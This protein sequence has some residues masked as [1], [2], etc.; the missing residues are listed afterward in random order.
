VT[1]PADLAAILERAAVLPP[2]PGDRFT[3]YAILGVP[4]RSG[5][6]LALRRF[7]VASTGPGYTSVWHRDPQGAWT[8]YSDAG[9]DQDGRDHGCGRYFGRAVREFIGTP[10]RIEWTGPRNMTIA[11]QG[12]RLLSWRL[13][14][15]PTASTT[16]LNAI[17]AHVPRRWLTDE[18]A[19]RALGLAAGFALGA[20]R[21]SLAGETPA[22]HRFMASPEVVWTVSASRAAVEGRDLGPIGPIDP[23]PALGDFYIP[24]RGLFAVCS[25]VMMMSAR[26]PD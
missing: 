16:L 24:R 3:G 18:R 20:G 8:F 14:L 6:V 4:F 2:G 25:A 22:G 1:E 21:L 9:C 15:A 12:G 10:I 23:Q 26:E 13:A 19:L 5:D 17:A 7:P 11:A